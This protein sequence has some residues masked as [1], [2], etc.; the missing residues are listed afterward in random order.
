[1]LEKV[2]VMHE[3]HYQFYV[4]YHQHLGIDSTHN[5]NRFFLFQVVVLFFG[6]SSL[7]PQCTFRL[8][9]PLVPVTAVD[10][11]NRSVLVAYAIL[12][13]QD[14]ESFVWMLEKLKQKLPNNTSISSII[15]DQDAALGSALKQSLPRTKHLLCK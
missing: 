10:G 3:V 5:T 6:C 11:Y 2:F 7:I 13:R 8:R 12:R 4:R 9:M 14:T 1:M 15:I